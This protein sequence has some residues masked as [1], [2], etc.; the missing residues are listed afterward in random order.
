MTGRHPSRFVPR[1]DADWPRVWLFTDERMAG[2]PMIAA[3]ALPP[4]SGIVFRHYATPKAERH[5]LFQR[6]LRIARARRHVLL[7]GGDY[8]LG[9]DGAHGSA[10]RGIRAGELPVSIGVHNPREAALAR[11]L[12]A[13][14]IFISPVFAT[15]SH[16]DTAALRAAGFARLSAGFHG[17][18]IALGGMDAARFRL[19]RRHGAHGWGA[20][21]SLGAK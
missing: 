5:R 17:A 11:R 10:W 1:T 6:L 7:V 19:L 21:D 14:L 2:C 13:R 8:L 9:A 20:I 16:V 3:R 4:R 12:G 15:R 18:C